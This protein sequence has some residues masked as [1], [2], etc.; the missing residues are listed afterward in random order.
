MSGIPVYYLLYNPS[1]IPLTATVPVTLLKPPATPKVGCR[2]VPAQ[3]LAATTQANPDGYHPT[4][5]DVAGL[6]APFRGP[7]RAGWRLEYFAAD[8]LVSCREGHVATDTTDHVL[9]NLFYNRTG[10][11]AAAI[12]VTVDAPPDTELVLP[13]VGPPTW[14]NE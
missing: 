3:V 12:A 10:P 5:A 9:E 14:R 4:F 8:F 7:H 2:V 1:T 11:I 13:D 6:A